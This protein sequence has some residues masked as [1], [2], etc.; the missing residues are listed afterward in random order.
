MKNLIRPLRRVIALDPLW[1]YDGIVCNDF[2]TFTRTYGRYHSV[3]GASFRYACRFD[4]LA[5]EFLFRASA[6]IGGVVLV[7]EEA[8]MYIDNGDSF[9]RTLV[10][11]GRHFGVSL[12]CVSRRVPDLPPFF[13]AQCSTI[14]SFRQWEPAD[15]ARL[16]D[17]GMNGETVRTLPQYES[18]SV[19]KDIDNLFRFSPSVEIPRRLIAQ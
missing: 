4:E 6:L 16:S 12:L 8:D 2:E 11:Q 10:N 14:V 15:V 19:G 3:P 17:I 18:L 13:R 9:F 1:E 5:A 7:V